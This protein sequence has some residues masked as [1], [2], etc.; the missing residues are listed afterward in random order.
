MATDAPSL[1]PLGEI[2][3]EDL[4]EERDDLITEPTNQELIVDPEE[5][6]ED[7]EEIIEEENGLRTKTKILKTPKVMRTLI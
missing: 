6:Q 5:E 7:Q 3:N 4:E 1:E 2:E